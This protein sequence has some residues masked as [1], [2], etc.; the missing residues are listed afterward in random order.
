[1]EILGRLSGSIQT[2]RHAKLASWGPADQALA[3][4]APFTGTAIY[5]NT[6]DAWDEG[7]WPLWTH[8]VRHVDGCL[9][10]A[11]GP[12]LEP[13]ETVPGP[14]KNAVSDQDAKKLFKRCNIVYVGWETT[15]KHHEYHQTKQFAEHSVILRCGNDGFAEYGHIVFE[16]SREKVGG[17][18]AKL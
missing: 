12:L 6:T 13:V 17:V 2:V 3:R 10:G 8:V 18:M 1:M 4:G 15:E 5:F 7:A 14:L 16:G 11:G 9:G